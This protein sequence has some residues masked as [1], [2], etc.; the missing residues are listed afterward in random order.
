MTTPTERRLAIT[1]GEAA[2]DTI[3]EALGSARKMLWLTHITHKSQECKKSSDL[4]AAALTA[5]KSLEGKPSEPRLTVDQVM[6]VV[7]Q[8]VAR[9]A[10]STIERMRADEYAQRVTKSIRARLTQSAKP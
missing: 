10:N 2:I 4:C 5:L 7:E 1:P 9:E 3:R 6:E 8:W